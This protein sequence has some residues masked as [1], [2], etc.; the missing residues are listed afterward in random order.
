MPVPQESSL[1]ELAMVYNW[2]STP[3]TQG[4]VPTSLSR[5]GKM[6]PQA[7]EHRAKGGPKGH[8]YYTW[9]GGAGDLWGGSFIP[10]V[11]R[12]LLS[13]FVI[14]SPSAF[15]S[16]VMPLEDSLYQPFSWCQEPHGQFFL[17]FQ[18]PWAAQGPRQVLRHTPVPG[19]SFSLV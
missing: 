14:E 3:N 12:C 9:W 7:L 17:F 2:F 18:R 5:D 4:E 13:A 19:A 15:F 16:L 1:T 8:R 6:G 10:C 11:K